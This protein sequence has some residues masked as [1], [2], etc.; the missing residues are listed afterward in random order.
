[1]A[2]P[3]RQ[4]D[5]LR[6]LDAPVPPPPAPRGSAMSHSRP[7]PT[8]ALA[9]TCAPASLGFRTTA[10]LP[11]IDT[12]VGQD[13]ATEAIDL[14]VGIA[15][16]G[17]NVFALGPS[18]IGKMTALRRTLHPP[19]RARPDARRLVLRPRRRRTRSG[20]ARSACPAGQAVALRVAMVQLCAEVQVGARRRLRE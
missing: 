2:L 16:P 7:L 15:G 13:R 17:F 12:I 6:T 14:A 5:G 20:R 4:R 9:R 10:E 8:S 19:G 11:D 1:M 18:G 3:A